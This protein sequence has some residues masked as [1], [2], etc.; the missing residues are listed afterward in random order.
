MPTVANIRYI[1]T[2]LP[3]YVQDHCNGKSETL[4][5]IDVDASTE[6]WELESMLANAWREL[7][8]FEDEPADL[9]A[10]FTSTLADMFGA[11]DNSLFMPD[12]AQAVEEDDADQS[13]VAWFRVSWSVYED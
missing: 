4:L 7:D 1:E 12:L 11:K 3:D 13:S 6:V 9:D 8:S 5:G 2:C 10:A